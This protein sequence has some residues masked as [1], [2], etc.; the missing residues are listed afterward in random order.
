MSFD[1]TVSHNGLKSGAC[2]L[3]EQKL[4]RELISLARR[5]HIHELIIAKVF[6]AAMGPSNGPN[7]KLFQRFASAWETIDKSDYK[8]AMDDASVVTELEPM[9][10]TMLE[11][12]R[13]QQSMFQP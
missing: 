7:I 13:H 6:D 1:T 12:I 5:H 9:K 8:S 10:I 4:N 11:F 2:L 3:L